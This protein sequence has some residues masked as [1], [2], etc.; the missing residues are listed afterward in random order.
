MQ[1]TETVSDR[2]W[3]AY[4]SL[5]RD[6][7]GKPPKRVDLERAHGLPQALFSKLFR[8]A[9]VSFSMK[10]WKAIASA[11]QVSLDWLVNGDGEPPS[12]TG[13]VPERPGQSRAPNL[14]DPA[15]WVAIATAP[16][17]S[18]D[19]SRLLQQNAFE[20]A[21]AYWLGSDE[22]TEGDVATIREQHADRYPNGY[23]TVGWGKI[24]R[25]KA[26][27]RSRKRKDLAAKRGRGS[28]IPPATTPRKASG[29]RGP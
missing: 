5:P 4:H 29:D 23:T 8:G 20:V 12:P 10:T 15:N 26:A 3:L 16:D 18:L 13:P 22:V 24:F 2:A 27:E 17:G 28:G 7:A 21:A 11:L 9:R 6:S 25:E 14:S 1:P 19:P